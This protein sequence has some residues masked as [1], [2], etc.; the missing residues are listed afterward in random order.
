[1]PKPIRALAALLLLFVP[2]AGVTQEVSE[3]TLENGLRVIVKEDHRA[4]VVVSQVWYKVGSSYEYDGITGVSHMLEHMMFQGTETRAPGEA[5]RIIAENGGQ[6]NAFTSR[7]YTAYYQ[8]LEASRLPIA[9]ELEADRMRNLQLREDRFKKERNVVM[10][11]RRLRTEDKP[12]SLTYET[13]V[14]TAYQASPYR[15]PVIGWMDD[16][17][18]YRLADLKQW[19]RTWYAPNNAVVVVAGAVNP[20]EVFRLAEKHFGPL[21]PST[22]LPPKPRAEPAQRGERRVRVRAPAELPYL[23]MGYKAPVLQTAD[24]AWKPYALAVLAG[25]LDSGNSARL[26][27]ELVRGRQIAAAVG[28]GYG[29]YGRYEGLL[30]LSGVP[31]VGH[32]IPAL[33]AAL[34]DQI[35]RL[36]EEPVAPAELERIKAQVVAADVYAK[37]SVYGQATEIGRLVTVGLDWRLADEYVERISAVTPEQVRQ[38]ANEFL[39]D[40]RLTVAVLDPLPL[41]DTPASGS[42]M[43]EDVDAIH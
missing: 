20:E 13:F 36:K 23:I 26:T 32:D 27:R 3:R 41:G 2:L 28:A 5:S 14:A 30:T 16:I 24:E 38:V 42:D 19:Y 8:Q 21:E 37:D 40:E 35:L 31:A 39:S 18:N 9:F 15:H 7:D 17:R 6:E 33:E 12:R 34:R 25:V 11:E 4:P 43:S 29:L 1:M 22:L 10:E